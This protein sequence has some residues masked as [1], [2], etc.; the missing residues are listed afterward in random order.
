[1]K[2]VMNPRVTQNAGKFLSGCIIISFWR[3]TQLHEWVSE[4]INSA[5][6]I[7]VPREECMRIADKL[8]AQFS[9]SLLFC[10]FGWLIFHERIALV[11]AHDCGD[12]IFIS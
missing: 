8:S 10:Y 6:I 1:V 11:S 9:N 12:S 5:Y 2:A 7:V 3:R 4:W